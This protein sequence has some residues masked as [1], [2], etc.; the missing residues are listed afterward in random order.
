[1]IVPYSKN[2]FQKASR[3]RF[4]HYFQPSRVIIG[5][6]PAATPSGFN[7]ITLC[8]HMYCSYKPPMMAFAIQSGSLSHELVKKSSEV[9]LAVPGESLAEEALFCGVNS[10]RDID[11]LSHLNLS[12][13]ESYT[14]AVPSLNEAI[15]NVEASIVRLVE[16]GDHITAIVEVKH[17]S[18][19]ATSVER[20]LLSVGPRTAGYRVLAH[21]GIHRLGVA[22]S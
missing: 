14:I 3:Q 17:F 19:D 2:T 11:K 15:A 6:L 18:V 20:P 7:P 13:H 9:S 1:M 22:D 10:G 12:L 4:R 8:F 21:Q 16:T 5:I